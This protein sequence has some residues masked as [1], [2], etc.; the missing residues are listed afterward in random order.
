ME[1]LQCVVESI[2]FK[3]EENGY[4][5]A[6]TEDEN[7]KKITI[8][9]CIPYIMEGQSLKISGEWTV[10]PQFGQQFKVEKCDEI[11]PNSLVGIEKYLASGVI[12]GIG[13]VTA[14]KIVDKFG[15]KTLEVLDN[16][17]YRLREIDGIGDKK[18]EL[19]YESYSQQREI[20]N[21][22]IFLQTYGVTPNQC[23]KIYKKYKSKAIEVVKEN[24]Y[25]LTDTIAGI[26][27][28]T[29]DKIARSLGIEA[30][31][32][33]RIQSGITYVVNEFCA[34]GNTYMP[35]EDLIKKSIEILQVR[36]DEIEKGIY[37]CTLSQKLKVEIINKENCVYTMP[38][39]YSELGVTRK[40]ITLA[41]DK[42]KELDVDINSEIEK[43]QKENNIE[44]AASQKEAIEGAIKNG[45]EII[46]G[47]PGTG[48]TTIIRCITSI[49]EELSM[50]VF[51]AAPTG[52]AAKRMSEATGSEARTIH[53]MLELGYEDEEL[54]EKPDESILQ[55]DVIIID[56]AS[57]IDIMLMHSLL[58]AIGLGTR[59]IIVG[60]V[61]QL[62]SVGPGNVLR[63][64]IESNCVKVFKLKEIFRQAKESMIIVNAHKI[65]NGEMPILNKKDN[66]FYFI[67][68]EKHDIILN[69]ILSLTCQRLPKYNRSW[70][71]I[72]D[73]QI[74]TP[75]KKGTLGVINMNN[76]LQNV[77]NPKDKLKKEIKYRDVIF[78]VG[79]K[80]MQN[81]NNY[82]LKWK[83]IK[84]EG[85]K[86]GEG[87]FN[88]DIGFVYD[89]DED[90][91]LIVLFDD[92]REVVYEKLNL[93]ELSLAYAVTI[94]KSQGSEFPVVIMPAFVGPPL[95]MNRNLLYT[96]ITRAKQFVVIVGQKKAVQ[97]MINN[98]RS[99]KR[100]SGLE[101][102]ISEVLNGEEKN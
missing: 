94:H 62:P 45:F 84:G 21:I 95:L 22:M 65:N 69:T 15:D 93:D 48:K 14:K 56:E 28:K 71:S 75:M 63:D 39:Y 35:I 34:M 29:A 2:V 76:N 54:F 41:Y 90:S 33:F 97:F 50:K 92:E 87:V 66:D 98:N 86:E 64:L 24:P 3:N 16:D 77:L 23:V 25:I 7:S 55:C 82:M 38:Y 58:K 36:K 13:P 8:T 37:E 70:D 44:F 47:G 100:Y 60:D 46:T 17:V 59:L 12:S 99:F 102:R 101:W 51:M 81:K 42:Y 79:D 96:A 4:V 9:G 10:H 27:F 31:S 53:R 43:F 85:E 40:I 18:I 19:I 11:L 32:P 5:V 61:D 78:R 20:R 67:S 91:N 83:R 6:I 49:F 80:V 72:K 88:G 30:N 26:G 68:E 73:I 1:E 52:R 74:I 57:M 89:I